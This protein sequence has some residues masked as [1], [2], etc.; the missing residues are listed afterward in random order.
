MVLSLKSQ[1]GSLQQLNSTNQ[2]SSDIRSFSKYNGNNFSL[3]YPAGWKIEQSDMGVPGGEAIRLSNSQF[4]ELIQVVLT[5]TDIESLKNATQ[6][7]I[8]SH[9]E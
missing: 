8:E 2:N 6:A 5:P 9:L 3:Q 1:T 7:E 4:S